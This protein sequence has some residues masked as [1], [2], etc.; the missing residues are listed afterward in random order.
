MKLHVEYCK[1]FG[2]SQEEMEKTEEK[3]GKF[4][5]RPLMSTTRSLPFASYQ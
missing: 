3:E 5:T 1:G 2:I 4:S